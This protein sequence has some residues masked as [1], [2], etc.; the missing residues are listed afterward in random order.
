MSLDMVIYTDRYG[1]SITNYMI[2]ILIMMLIISWIRT[3]N[4][5][6]TTCAAIFGIYLLFVIRN[7]LFP[8][9]IAGGFADAMRAGSFMSG[10]NLIPFNFPYSPEI[11]SIT[12]EL[13][14]NIVLLVPFGFG[15]SFLVPFRA[16]NVF[17][18][19]PAVGISIEAIQLVISLIIGYPYRVIDINDAIMNTLG[20][21]IGYGIF[22][23]FAWLYIAMTHRLNIEHVGLGKYIYGIANRATDQESAD[24]NRLDSGI[25]LTP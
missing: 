6:H 19:A 25:E 21:L 5:S 17:W 9:H 10:F 20:F 1:F 14:L 8:L 16:K 15:L 24:Y 12:L 11:S 22:R 3:R 13:G 18:L 23:L 2:G 4:L 7:T